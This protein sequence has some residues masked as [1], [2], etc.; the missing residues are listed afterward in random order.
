MLDAVKNQFLSLFQFIS[1]VIFNGQTL[2]KV[3]A[4]REPTAIDVETLALPTWEL[5]K[6]TNLWQQV[7]R[8]IQ[9]LYYGCVA[10][11]VYFFRYYDWKQTANTVAA[12]MAE[13]RS[14]LYT[15]Y[16][17]PW[18]KEKAFH[19]YGLNPESLTAAQKEDPAILLLHGKGSNQSV[20]I[21]LAK[22][23]Q[24]KGISNVF[25]LN[26]NDG[27]LTDEDI[28][29]LEAKLQEIQALYGEKQAKII[30]IGHSRG[31]E[32]SL[33]AGLPRDT[34]KLDDGYCYQTKKWEAFR[35][36]ILLIV[37]LGSPLL[38]EERDQLPQEMQDCVYE[39]DGLRDL[40]I[41]DRS[42]DPYY[43]ADCGHI[44]LLYHSGVHQK[45]VELVSS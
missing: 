30:L 22:T 36:E 25:T 19:Y 20:W 12:L 1:C 39:I 43:Q 38:K 2:R 11:V 40:I 16:W 23:F 4:V 35:S 3:M 17:L 21:E 14:A 29:L 26:S 32:F 7:I 45:I 13:T 31:A 42:V 6:P 41:P 33:Y 27:E 8:S 24:E 5:P 10:R 18:G 9:S 28:P 15:G 37:R 34:F 44:E